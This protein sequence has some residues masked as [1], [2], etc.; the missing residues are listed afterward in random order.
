MDPVSPPQSNNNPMRQAH[1]PITQQ[2]MNPNPTSSDKNRFLTVLSLIILAAVVV[3]TL[4]LYSRNANQTNKYASNTVKI[5]NE[6]SPTPTPN[7]TQ[8][9]L[10]IISPTENKA[11]CARETSI[12]RALKNPDSVCILDLS[13]ENL[14]QIPS[15]I[16][17]FKNLFQLDV[18][19]NN[20]STLPK[21]LFSLEKLVNLNLSNNSFTS[22]PGEI[23]SLS[24]LQSLNLAN[25]KLG[26]VPESLSELKGLQ[27]LKLKQNNFTDSEKSK[28]KNSF[29]NIKSVEL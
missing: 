12:E 14:T 2:E 28:I 13:S 25:N 7:Q 10:P 11:I 9:N 8:Y 3:V 27:L 26:S 21:E 23:S 4:F 24:T 20:L 18:S 17:K 5:N 15:S 6:A 16:G 19:N 29:T 22:I 1:Y